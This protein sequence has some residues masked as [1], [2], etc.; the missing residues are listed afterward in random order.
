[1]RSFAKI[2]CLVLSF[3]LIMSALVAC[4]DNDDDKDGQKSTTKL[5]ITNVDSNAITDDFG[6][7]I[8]LETDK[9]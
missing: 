7:L 1:M 9:D 3:L 8:P 2:M 4:I 5:S 6:P